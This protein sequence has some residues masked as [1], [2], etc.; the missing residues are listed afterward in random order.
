MAVQTS[1]SNDFPR[2][3][4]GMTRGTPSRTVERAAASA[5]QAGVLVCQGA[6]DGACKLPANS[7]DVGKALGVAASRVASDSRFPST[8]TAGVAWQTGDIV[9]AIAAGAVWVIVEDAVNAGAACYVRHTANGDLTQLGAFRSDADSSNA[10]A[11]TGARFLTSTDGAG[12]ALV[13][14]NVP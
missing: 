10:A 4:A 1:V 8:L 3:L 13:A 14:I 9:E 2:A 7:G 6:T 5:I 12:L 11:L